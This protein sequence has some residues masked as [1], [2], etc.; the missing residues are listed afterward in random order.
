M[1]YPLISVII[2]V[3][4]TT[5]FL[6][7][8][9]SSLIAQTYSNW[10]GIVIDDASSDKEAIQICEKWKKKDKR[11][12]LISFTKNSGI[13]A[14][15]NRGITEANGDFITFLDSD[16]FIEKSHLSALYL[17]IKQKNN[18]I[19]T[20]A[21]KQCTQLGKAYRTILKKSPHFY[22][23]TKEAVRELLMDRYLTSHLCNKMFPKSLLKDVHFPQDRVYE[24][25]AVLLNIMTKSNGV[26][27]TGKVTYNYRRHNNSI[28]KVNSVKNLVDFFKANLERYYFLNEN[29]LFS[30]KENKVL[31]IWY[32][33]TILRLVQETKKCSLDSSEKD[34][35]INF[36][37]K[38]INIL[39]MKEITSL[40]RLRMLIFSLKKRFYELFYF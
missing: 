17:A 21:I 33:K 32:K 9:F 18:S 35:A 28:T 38:E 3:F 39:G 36:M 19:A 24:D 16:D 8:C 1:N 22:W 2:P 26:I 13:S 37:R 14:V 12:K 20:T 6:D 25:F 30:K 29:T 23:N 11:I 40:Y 34:N 4:N 5:Q 7:D 27:H 10:E 31:M 15:R